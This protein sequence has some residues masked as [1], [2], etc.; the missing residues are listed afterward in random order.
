[1]NLGAWTSYSL[2]DFLL[3]SDIVYWRLLAAYNEAMWPAQLA[4]VL[5]GLGMIAGLVR[6]GRWQSRAVV[7]GLAVLWGWVAWGFFDQRYQTINWAAAYM[8]PVFGGQAVFLAVAALWPTPPRLAASAEPGTISLIIL[9]FAVLIYPMLAPAGGRSW[10]S[11][12]VFGLSPDPTAVATLAVIACWHHPM[13]WLFAAVPL[14]W[15]LATGLTLYTLGAPHFFAAPVLA[16]GALVA[17]ALPTV[18]RPAA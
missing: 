1:M 14:M 18:N 7:L 11:G 13:R 15:S 8:V 17:A 4:L 5:A 12:E 10:A 16:F 9:A 3:F 6:T 2:S